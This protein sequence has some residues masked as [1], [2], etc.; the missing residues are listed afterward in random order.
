MLVIASMCL[1]SSCTWLRCSLWSSKQF[2]TTQNIFEIKIVN[3]FFY[4]LPISCTSLQ[5]IFLLNTGPVFAT[6]NVKNYIMNIILINP[7]VW[8]TNL[9]YTFVSQCYVHFEA[10]FEVQIARLQSWRFACCTPWHHKWQKNTIRQRI[11]ITKS[12]K[13]LLMECNVHSAG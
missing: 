10:H 7:T 13:Y 9:H 1:I 11:P 12:L 4:S 2:F 6:L 3:F 5:D 8:I